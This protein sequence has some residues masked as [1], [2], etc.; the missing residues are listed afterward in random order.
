[1]VKP[2]AR[3]AVG[4]DV[5]EY[6]GAWR[7]PFAR[8]GVVQAKDAD[9]V[10]PILVLVSAEAGWA[11][12]PALVLADDGAQVGGGLGV[13]EGEVLVA[14]GDRPEPVKNGGELLLG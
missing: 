10:M 9:A 11:C 1:M 12:P 7:P 2:G 3:F 13:L 14:G 5:L 6:P 8:L 4:G